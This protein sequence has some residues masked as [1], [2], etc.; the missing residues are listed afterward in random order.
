MYKIIGII[1][2]LF[3][4]SLNTGI[5]QTQDPS[6]LLE[7]SKQLF[8]SRQYDQAQKLL[9]QII[10]KDPKQ[11]DALMLLGDI[12]MKKENWQNAK[13][14]Y[15]D[16]TRIKAN[17]IDAFYKLGI[18]DREDGIGRDMVTQLI[19]WKNSKKNFITVLLL[20]STYKQVYYEYA[21]LKRYQKNYDEAID[22]CLQQLK[23]DPDNHD[24]LLGIFYFYDL[25]ITYAGE[26]LFSMFSD[27][28]QAQIDWLKKRNQDIDNFFIGEKYR[29]MGKF[30]KA[31]SI[32]A[33]LN[34]KHNPL[35]KIPLYLARVRLYYQM[36]KPHIAE[37]YYN[38]AVN[39]IDSNVDISFMFEDIKYILRDED[40]QKPLNSLEAVRAFYRNIWN[41]KNPLNSLAN[42]YRLE[43]H[44]KRLIYCE[45]NYR[46]DGFRFPINNPDRT[47]S[48]EFP[49][50]FYN[51][52]KFNHKGLVYLRYGKPDETAFKL[53]ANL[54]SNESWLYNATNKHPKYIFHF[55]VADQAP[56]NDWRLVP[57]PTN[58]LMLETRLGW[59]RRLDQ[60][61]MATNELD[62]NSMIGSITIDAVKKVRYAMNH[63]QHSW[64]KDIK[65]VPF[66]TSAGWFMD[67][68]G[69]S[70]VDVYLSSPLD[71]LES[72]SGISD[73]GRVETGVALMDSNWNIIYKQQQLSPLDNHIY[74]GQYLEKYTIPSPPANAYLNTHITDKDKQFLGGD[75]AVI[76]AKMP[77]KNELTVSD[78]L[79]AY[80]V[81][82]VAKQN[83]FTK[84]GLQVIPNP[85]KA[86]E[87]D[88]LIYFY[89]E[90]YNLQEIGGQSRYR[91]DQTV[92]PLN[93]TKNVLQK[94][95]GLFGGGEDKTISISKEHQ[96]KGPV[97]YEYTAFDFSP[98][99][100]GNVEL[101]I[102]I[103]DLNSGKETRAHSIFTLF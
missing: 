11:T 75:Q 74:Y 62:A 50:I 8:E 5:A 69:K 37:E 64:D 96:A 98:L 93:K 77:D 2:I 9:K 71:D 24:A 101:I 102:N 36:D 30:D 86:A 38:K 16:V 59:D 76:H 45:K 97:A 66:Y 34:N 49:A 73:T 56:A 79:M 33:Q 19:M 67:K 52:K 78:L 103:K 82:P 80:D 88:S 46:Y 47:N 26:N 21:L 40:L 91:I 94:L 99:D 41:Q 43:E 4:L 6:Q 92:K 3:C 27:V 29:R 54:P 55:E 15:V 70:V 57:V 89:Y 1:F 84:H 90:I 22:L 100:A 95:I 32:F 7:E 44:Y 83:A 60:Y 42:N 87:K 63:E 68:N 53:D 12:E 17:N 18:C 13:D 28:D 65:S 25:F 14:W 58:P 39:S 35:L 20:D 72:Q 85:R 81:E 10:K 31:D 23:I 61:Y 51:N 48:L